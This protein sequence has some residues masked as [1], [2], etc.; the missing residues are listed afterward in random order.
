MLRESA[1]KE[2]K[3]QDYFFTK[4]VQTNAEFKTGSNN[5]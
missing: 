1:Q 2:T 4:G 5:F 3:M